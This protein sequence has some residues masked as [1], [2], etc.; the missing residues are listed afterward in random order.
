[1]TCECKYK[2][3]LFLQ[4]IN[5]ILQKDTVKG[6]CWKLLNYMVG[7]Q[8]ANLGKIIKKDFLRLLCKYLLNYWCVLKT[9]K[10]IIIQEILSGEPELVEPYSKPNT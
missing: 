6:N 2:E 8:L 7:G 5:R 4:K 3:L 9:L 10:C 1:M